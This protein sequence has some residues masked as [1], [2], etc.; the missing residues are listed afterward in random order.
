MTRYYIKHNGNKEACQVMFKH[1]HGYY[2]SWIAKREREVL[3][4]C[5]YY[6]CDSD[7]EN[8]GEFT[9]NK[10]DCCEFKL[11]RRRPI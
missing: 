3:D 10:P 1:F 11:E 4:A 7:S 6:V 2:D 5:P 8:I 9:P